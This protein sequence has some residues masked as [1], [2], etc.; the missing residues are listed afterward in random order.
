MWQAAIRRESLPSPQSEIAGP[1]QPPGRQRCR[2]RFDRWRWRAIK[3]LR[4]G[5]DWRRPASSRCT[6]FTMDQRK[7]S[8]SSSGSSGLIPDSR[9][10]YAEN[11]GWHF[12]RRTRAERV[13]CNTTSCDKFWNARRP[14]IN[15]IPELLSKSHSPYLLQCKKARAAFRHGMNEAILTVHRPFGG[16]GGNSNEC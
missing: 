9:R 8:Q 12:L 3:K 16:C 5:K 15:P 2:L 11:P 10:S 1:G 4:A 7:H 14:R 6:I 13:Q